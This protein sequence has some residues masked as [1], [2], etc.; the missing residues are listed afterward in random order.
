MNEQ[1][2]RIFEIHWA[3]KLGIVAT[4]AGLVFGIFYFAAYSDLLGDVATME[5]AIQGPKGLRFQVSQQREIIRNLPKFEQEV[6]ALEVE[7]K[8]A[9]TELPDKKEIYVL[10]SK[11]SEKAKDSG[12]SVQL[13]KPQAEQKKD[14]YSEVPVQIQLAG[15]F[16][17]VATFFDEVGNLERIVNVDQINITEPQANDERVVLK[18]SLVATTFRFLEESERPKASE[19]KESKKHRKH[20]SA[21]ADL[22]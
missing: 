18:T 9:L 15:S 7:L 2:E 4:I 11:V 5:A 21:D 22:K 19:E 16:H 20:A 17:Q 8:K 10:L 1:I 6:A 12:L 14:F 13:F 3:A